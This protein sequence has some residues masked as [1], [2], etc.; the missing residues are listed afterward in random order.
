VG[1]TGEFQKLYLGVSSF[2]GFKIKSKREKINYDFRPVN[3]MVGSKK[4][5][6]AYAVTN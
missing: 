5:L 2:V 6:Q 4:F 3:I 1:S